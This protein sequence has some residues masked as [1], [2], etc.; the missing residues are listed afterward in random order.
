MK[1]SY[2]MKWAKIVSTWNS[3]NILL[4]FIHNDVSKCNFVGK[5]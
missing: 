3:E 5:Y 4:H 1:Y 2:V